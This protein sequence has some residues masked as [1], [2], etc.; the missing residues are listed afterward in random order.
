[1][2]DWNWQDE[3]RRLVDMCHDWINKRMRLDGEDL[4]HTLSD[5]QYSKWRTILDRGEHPIIFR[6][7]WGLAVRAAHKGNGNGNGADDAERAASNGNGANGNGNG[8]DAD[9]G[10]AAPN[11]PKNEG[12]KAPF[13]LRFFEPFDATTLPPRAFLFGRH[14]QRR[15]VSGTVAPGGTGKSSLVMVEAVAMAAGRDLFG[16][17]SLT[18]RVRVWY[19]NGQTTCSN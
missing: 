10:E 19:H 6:N 4:S 15:T 11:A 14:Y 5:E 13:V 1:M 9:D 3:E 2:K 18:E 7:R 17:G 8:N 16:D 12:P